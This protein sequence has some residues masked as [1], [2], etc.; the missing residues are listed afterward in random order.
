MFAQVAVFTVFF[1]LITALE[2][3]TPNPNRTSFT[4]TLVTL[5]PQLSP[6]ANSNCSKHSDCNPVLRNLLQLITGESE[7]PNP[8]RQLQERRAFQ[9]LHRNPKILCIREQCQCGE[10]AKKQVFDPV[11]QICRSRCELDQDCFAGGLKLAGRSEADQKTEKANQDVDVDPLLRFAPGDDLN[12]VPQY[13]APD[14]LCRCPGSTQ[15]DLLNQSRCIVD[16]P[17]LLATSLIIGSVFVLFTIIAVP[18]WSMVRKHRDY[19]RQQRIP[20]HGCKN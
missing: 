9:S 14:R 19:L 16:T 12:V 17:P 15:L 8:R 11:D 10:E 3:I 2:G 5:S 13:C 6:Q 4:S 7:E 18:V 1:L 20:L